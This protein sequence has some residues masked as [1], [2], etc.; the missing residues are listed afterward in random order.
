MGCHMT[1]PNSFGSFEKLIELLAVDGLA[2]ESEK[3]ENLLK[4]VAWTSGSE[5]YGEF[6]L[7]M[8]KSNLTNGKK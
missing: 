4:K 7:E 8:K 3:L 5:F 6:G 2:P 1:E